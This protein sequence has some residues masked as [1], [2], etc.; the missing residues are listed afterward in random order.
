VPAIAAPTNVPHFHLD[1]SDAAFVRDPYPLLAH[2]R[3]EM[4]V[5]WDEQWQKLFFLRY[6]DIA[7]LLRDKRLGRSLGKLNRDE[8]GFPPPNPALREFEHFQANHILDMEPPNHSRIRGLVQKAFTPARIEALRGHIWQMV[9]ESLAN[10]GP[11]FDAVH[12]FAEPLPVTVIAELLGV[13][14]ADRQHLRPWS[15]AIVKLFELDYSAAQA[16]AGNRAV[17]EFSDYVRNL[18]AERRKQPQDDLITAMVQVEEAGEKLSGDELV[19]NCILFLNAGH[20]AT[21]NGLSNALLHLEQ[22]PTQ[23]QLLIDASDKPEHTPLWRTAIEELL[24][25]DTPLPMFERWVYEDFEYNGI[26]IPKGTELGLMYASG[27]RDGEKFEQPDRLDLRRNPNYHLTFGLGTHYCLGAPLA[28]LEM[29]LALQVFLA[30]F[31]NYRIAKQDLNYGGFVIRGLE[32][33]I[34]EVS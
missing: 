18:A 17:I 32:Q 8:L 10:V 2:L 28:R 20:E 12:A 1:L 11:S 31:P 7:A 21:V 23:R 6:Q 34:V 4:P 25:F 29:T 33:L 3:A 27:N 13:P 26:N 30:H 19:A 15:A 24:R 22:H 9:T 14:V 5:F 16:A